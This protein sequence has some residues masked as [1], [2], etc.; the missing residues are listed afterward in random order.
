VYSSYDKKV[1]IIA[2]NIFNNKHTTLG[3]YGS[4]EAR[5]GGVIDPVSLT[6]DDEILI[7]HSY[8]GRNTILQ[9]WDLRSLTQVGTA[10]LP[11]EHQ[12]C[13]FTAGRVFSV[14]NGAQQLWQRNYLV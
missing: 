9:M 11:G 13:E 10:Q 6:L 5:D 1:Y 14:V 2:S 8:N 7:A 3:V 12:D 4:D